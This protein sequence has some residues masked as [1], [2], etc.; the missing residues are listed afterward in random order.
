[1]PYT[2]YFAYGSNMNEEQ[3]KARCP[4][5]YFLCRAKLPEYRFIIT[6]SGYA[7]VVPE[8]GRVVHGVLCA[9]TEADERELDHREG[10]HDGS[11][12]RG[13]L[14]VVTEFG[15]VITALIYLDGAVG[16]GVPLDGY[17][18]AILS[19]ARRHELPMPYVAE[20]LS[21]ANRA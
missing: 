10:V 7:T 2:L 6:S 21:W 9:L 13:E 19:G 18:E 12:R 17:L 3:F 1:M 8:A 11:Y 5:S 4:A 20:I 16:E 15:Y 14:P